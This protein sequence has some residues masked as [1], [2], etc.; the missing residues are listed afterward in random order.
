VTLTG[1]AIVVACGLYIIY[2]ETAATGR[3]P[4]QVTSMGPDE[5]V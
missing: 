1:A 4:E 3:A 5:T 2:R